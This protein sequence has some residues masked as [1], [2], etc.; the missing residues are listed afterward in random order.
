MYDF[1]L[2]ACG[3]FCDRGGYTDGACPP[4]PV[5]AQGNNPQVVAAFSQVFVTHHPWRT[6]WLPTP[7]FGPGEFHGQEPGRLQTTGS[8]R[9]AYN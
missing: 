1:F 5:P 7:V 6:E 2:E 9:V 8:H 4:Q 3:D